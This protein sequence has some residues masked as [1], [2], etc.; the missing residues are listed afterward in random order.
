[1]TRQRVRGPHVTAA[2][3]SGAV[4]R[5]SPRLRVGGKAGG[6]TQS[7]RGQLRKEREEETE[8]AL[9]VANARRLWAFGAA[10]PSQG[11]GLAR[12]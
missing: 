12:R 4:P 6:L 11:A 7:V 9:L 5:S 8:N 1:M 10:L 2:V 3:T